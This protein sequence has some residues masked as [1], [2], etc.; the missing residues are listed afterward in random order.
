MALSRLLR[1]LV[2]SSWLHLR[3]EFLY[4][5]S[6]YLDYIYQSAEYDPV[7]THFFA[8]GTILSNGHCENHQA[9]IKQ[10]A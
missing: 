7:A 1:Q 5:A 6:V 3:R 4:D 8:L 2:R 9:N 10:Q